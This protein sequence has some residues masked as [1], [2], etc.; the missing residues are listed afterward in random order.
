MKRMLLFCMI[1]MLFAAMA[2]C[3]LT[4]CGGGNGDGGNEGED[5]P[6]KTVDMSAV[7]F[8]DKTVTYNGSAHT[9]EAENLPDG[10]T[11]TYTVVGDAILPGTYTVTATFTPPSGYEAIEDK[12]ATLTVE[13]A[14]MDMSA[15]VF[16]DKTVTYNAGKHTI[17]AENLPEGVT[18]E[19]TV[20]GDAILPG[21]YTVT[22]TFT[23]PQGYAAAPDR[24]AILTVEAAAIDMSQAT[25][26]DRTVTYNGEAQLPSVENLPLYVT[27]VT[28]TVE[29]DAILPGVYTVT[30]TFTVK[31]GYA[32]PA[33]MTATLVIEPAVMDMTGVAFGDKTVTYNGSAHTIEA[34]NLP[35]GVTA[36]Y[37]VVGDAI[38]PGTYTVTA[39]F[40][41]PSGYAA[42]ENKTATLT[43]EP[44]VMDMS[45]VVF[46]DKTVTYNA[47][48]HTIE[49]ENLPEG[50]TAEYT[51]AG[52]AILPGTYT[53][54]ATFTMPQG[55]AA[56]PDRTAILTVE[57]AAI[58]MS[59]AT[60]ADRTVTYNGEAQLPSV[61]NLPL[62][63][64]DVTYTVE[65]DAIL[66]GVY[67][68]TATFTVK[69]G[70]ASPAPMTATLVIEPAV[71]DMTGVAFGD[72]TVTYNG[73]AH[74]IE[75]ENLPDGVSAEYTVEGDAIL[76]GTYTVTATFT[77][78]QGYAAIE[79]KTATLTVEPAPV[80]MS[81]V[82]FA[83]KTVAYVYGN[84][85]YSILAEN[86]PDEIV[87]VTY[88]GNGQ[89][90]VGVYTV[91]ATFTVKE[92]YAAIPD[93]TATLTVTEEEKTSY[94]VTVKDGD[95]APVAGVVLS[96]VWEDQSYTATTDENGKATITLVP[97]AWCVS[98]VSVPDRYEMTEE[99]VVL[100][101]P[102]AVLTVEKTDPDNIVDI[103]GLT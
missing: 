72:K 49:A 26:A 78:P 66:P 98:V 47:G 38:L 3:L 81:A 87:S 1:W 18:A 24:T 30:A 41:P 54:T 74:T 80:D 16:A 11:A 12:T 64:T 84:T 51:V 21:T 86:L 58:D 89:T 22:A 67:T 62:Y 83:D 35:E 27:D 100:T 73:S 2:L 59:Q 32:S 17:E 99:T 9:I 15:V 101:K 50:V 63:V 77:V 65:G 102:N 57:A 37:T 31:E 79:S 28:Y 69:E 85:G 29:G 5:A 97:R 68:V 42:I 70:Y 8:A 6:P 7:V 95:G 55:Y 34:E 91:T 46:A 75:A 76:P 56:A 94:T 13:P 52:D 44:A 96:L 39:K 43:V 103:G 23:M 71:M 92:G 25:F 20:A 48:K 93:R 4:A 53:V 45:A 10:V 60:F 40:T 19:Y 14:V 36:E 33:P 88:T 61:E 90:E 82:V